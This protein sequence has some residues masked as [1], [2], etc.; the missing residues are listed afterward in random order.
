[1]EEDSGRKTTPTRTHND[2]V[3]SNSACAAIR[4]ITRV[5]TDAHSPHAIS[6]LELCL[7]AGTASAELAARLDQKRA[8]FNEFAAYSDFISSRGADR[9]STPSHASTCGGSASCWPPASPTHDRNLLVEQPASAEG[10]PPQ[11]QLRKPAGML[12]APGQ[13]SAGSASALRASPTGK[14]LKKIQRKP[15]I[16]ATAPNLPLWRKSLYKSSPGEPG[17]HTS[18]D[19]PSAGI[20]STLLTT[21]PPRLPRG[22]AGQYFSPSRVHRS[23]KGELAHFLDRAPLHTETQ[24]LEKNTSEMSMRGDWASSSTWGQLENSHQHHRLKARQGLCSTGTIEYMISPLVL[25]IPQADREGGVQGRGESLIKRQLHEDVGPCEQSRLHLKLLRELGGQSIL[26]Q[27]L[28]F[29]DALPEAR[30]D[31]KFV[32]ERLSNLQV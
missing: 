32:L 19:E 30:A 2:Y 22:R 4:S 17:A 1:M 24:E 31:A 20:S 3:Y 13:M 12:T 27:V 10:A 14:K 28:T 11:A 6:S 5:D 16:I 23:T 7:N 8:C 9:L 15:Q 18:A 29:P 25:K 26:A 21:S